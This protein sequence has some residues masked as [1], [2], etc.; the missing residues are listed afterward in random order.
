[1]KTQFS[2]VGR[3]SPPIPSAAF[4]KRV[5][6]GERTCYTIS[7]PSVTNNYN[8]RYDSRLST[9][10]LIGSLGPPIS[11]L[12]EAESEKKNSERVLFKLD[13]M[14]PPVGALF[15]MHIYD[16]QRSLWEK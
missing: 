8:D 15:L 9:G 6:G 5:G 12:Q 7:F 1:M 13:N 11:M 16:Q 2:V 3:I 10:G 14:E 4:R